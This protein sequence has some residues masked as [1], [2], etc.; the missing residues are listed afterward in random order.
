MNDFSDKV[1]IVTGGGTGIGRAVAEQFAEKGAQVLITGRREKPLKELYQRYP[2][3][4]RFLKADITKVEDRKSI[5]HSTIKSFGKI[6]VLVNNAGVG[7]FGNIQQVTDENFEQSYL[8]NLIAPASL[9][10]EAI[11]HLAATKGS[12]VNISSVVA[13][14]VEAG[15]S[16]Y[17]CSK[18]AL[19]Q[20]TRILAVELGV[21]GIRVN[22]V[23]PGTIKTD[24][25]KRSFELNGEALAS[26]TAL[27][28][29]GEPI[30]VAR[31]VL[32]LASEEAG[33]VTGQIL[34]ASG[35]SHL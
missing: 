1:V 30:D 14:S 34:D 6:D 17:S 35:G 7:L 11:P 28:R 29:G 9:I 32:L 5:I 26:I 15:S 16:A 8:T 18:A 23:A 2:K 13:K 10:R 31:V 33:W 22:A 20:L 27:K 12:V 24:M 3:K 4:I 19:N 21:V 25:T